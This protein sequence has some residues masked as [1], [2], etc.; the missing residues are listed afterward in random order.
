MFARKGN[1][2]YPVTEEKQETYIKRGYDIYD[3][4]GNLIK[5]GAG[6]SV[7]AEA[8]EAQEKELNKLKEQ[9]AELKEQLKELKEQ[10]AEPKEQAKTSK[11]NAKG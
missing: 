1:K 9:N 6:K 10:N 7:S 3:K 2:E 4:K 11:E 5:N 8:Y